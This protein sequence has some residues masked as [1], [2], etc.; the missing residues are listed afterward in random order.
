MGNK[1]KEELRE[2]RREE[3]GE[4]QRMKREEIRQRGELGITKPIV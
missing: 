4:K 3:T 1:E 2:E